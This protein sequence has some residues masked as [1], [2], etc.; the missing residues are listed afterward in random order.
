[1][2]VNMLIA[3]AATTMG[4]LLSI[5]SVAQTWTQTIAPTNYPGPGIAS[6]ADGTRLVAVAGNVNTTGPIYTSTNFGLSWISNNAPQL[7]WMSVCS[8]ADGTRLAA[9]VY[10]GAVWTNSGT[11]WTQAAA[12]STGFYE[13][14]IAS[15]ANGNKLV[16]VGG[17]IFV[18]TNSGQTWTSSAYLAAHG[19]AMSANGAT[20]LTLADISTNGGST[21]YYPH[22]SDI[23]EGRAMA[24]SVDGF[25][26]IAMGDD[27]ISLST[28]S[29]S[30]W[31]Q[32]K[33][34]PQSS[35]GSV[36]S[37]ADGTRLIL[38][39][40]LNV[41]PIY[42]STNGGLA[43]SSANVPDN[44]WTSVTSSADGHA[45]AATASAF[46]YPGTSVADGIW[47]FQSTPPPALNMNSTATNLAFS[48]LISSTNFV[49]QQNSDLTT[50]NWSSVTNMPVLNLTN[51]Q[52]Q[53]ALP[54]SAGNA[55]FRLKTP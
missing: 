18:S 35:F 51:L 30:T 15:S 28:N 16:A 4:C 2:K 17:S 34:A 10:S 45:L 14:S 25:K 9:T 21:W 42:I 7:N 22:T 31:F 48:W 43:W 19:V 33:S 37:S 6:S 29:G 26:M 39:A 47:T 13:D 20:I 32:A 1:M 27:G 41:S 46:I 8:S 53:V 23:G 3:M 50:T 54:A 52:N 38:A 55:F 49:L 44:Y 5:P 40:H 24:S 12:L 11:T 36:A